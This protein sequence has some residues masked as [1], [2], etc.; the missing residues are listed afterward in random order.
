MD[1]TNTKI[2]NKPKKP[3][4]TKAIPAQGP[5]D[6]CGNP[7]VPNKPTPN[8]NRPKRKTDNNELIYAN[9]VQ[10]VDNVVSVKVSHDSTNYLRT[11]KDGLSALYLINKLECIR[12]SIKKLNDNVQQLKDEVQPIAIGEKIVEIDKEFEMDDKGLM[13]LKLGKGLERD[14]QDYINVKL[15]RDTLGFDGDG[16]I[17]T[18][19]SGYNPEEK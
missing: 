13:H 2:N 19:W 10:K 16:R 11:S 8:Q 9:G 5:C 12:K 7:I 4:S 3:V 18:V 6:A 15:D 1:K 14:E 17:M